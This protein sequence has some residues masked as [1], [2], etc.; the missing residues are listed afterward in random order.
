[1]IKAILFD[2]DGILFDSE[3]YYMSGTIEWMK[4]KGY[5]G[6]DEQIYTIIGTNMK[7]TYEMLQKMLDY[8][9]SLEELEQFNTEYFQK[10]PLSCK[11][12]MFD[13]IPEVLKQ[14]KK[15]N[16]QT[17][18]CSSS[19]I[20]TI[21]RA[22]QEMGIDSLFDCVIASDSV[23]EPKPAPDVYLKA[24]EELGRTREECIVYEDSTFGI[25]SGKNAGVKVIA[26]E[27]KRFGQDQSQADLMVKDIYELLA[28]VKG[29]LEDGRSN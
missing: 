8:R 12:K 1:M 10:H 11:E 27:D 14:F 19:P 15:M 24:M 5:T 22:L 26:R 16:L 9:Y 13:G 7:V 6:S 29:E 18:V 4:E 2:M 3:G 25:Q 17:A 21:H 20:P 28:Y 23:K